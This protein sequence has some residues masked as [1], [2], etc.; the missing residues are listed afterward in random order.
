MKD[1]ITHHLN[2]REMNAP[3]TFLKVMQAFRR[4][5]AGEILEILGNDVQT[6]KYL[7]KVL[8]ASRYELIS[9]R[10]DLAYYQVLLRKRH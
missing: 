2:L 6:R 8:D 1:D 7:F 5:N 10:D 4:I 9:F 3:I